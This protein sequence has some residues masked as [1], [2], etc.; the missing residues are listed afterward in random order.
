MRWVLGKEAQRG[1]FSFYTVSGGKQIS[2]R[3]LRSWM[4]MSAA[5]YG[6]QSQA[7]TRLSV[8]FEAVNERRLPK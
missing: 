8:L 2:D 7:N 3:E 6:L 4:C 5:L 1:E